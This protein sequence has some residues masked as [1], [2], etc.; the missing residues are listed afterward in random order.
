MKNDDVEIIN[1]QLASG[2]GNRMRNRRLVNMY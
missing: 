1:R 2:N